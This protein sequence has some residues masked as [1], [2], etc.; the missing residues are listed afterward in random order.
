MA[1]LNDFDKDARELMREKGLNYRSL[2]KLT[3]ITYQHLS[4][5]TKNTADRK[6]AFIINR[7]FDTMVDTMGYD[8]KVEYI[9]KESKEDSD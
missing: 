4:R 1:V 2:S 6:A 8:I 5:T 7:T 9:P 3:G